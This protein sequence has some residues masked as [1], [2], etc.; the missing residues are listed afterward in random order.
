MRL[1]IPALPGGAGSKVVPAPTPKASALSEAGP[2]QNAQALP[3]WLRFG[4]R[5]ERPDPIN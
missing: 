5:R 3:A 4:N 1:T 2:A